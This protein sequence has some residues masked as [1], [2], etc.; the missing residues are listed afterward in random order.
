MTF[1]ASQPAKIAHFSVIRSKSC[2]RIPF[3]RSVSL[4]IYAEKQYLKHHRFLN[5]GYQIRRSLKLH[6]LIKNCFAGGF[7]WGLGNYICQRSTEIH[8]SVKSI[9]A[10]ALF[11]AIISTPLS[12]IWHN[13]LRG[14]LAFIPRSFSNSPNRMKLAFS[15]VFLTSLILSPTL[16]SCL[17]MWNNM[18]SSSSSSILQEVRNSLPPLL[19]ASYSFWPLMNIM[20]FMFI[21]QH[22]RVVAALVQMVLWSSI[23]SYIDIQKRVS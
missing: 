16:L 17:I 11:G 4:Q 14:G 8:I 13:L 19:F 18:N 15:Q 20:N 1:I 12:F 2:F 3:A 6:S 5:L 7:A 22:A 23:C 21:P 10:A 9:Y